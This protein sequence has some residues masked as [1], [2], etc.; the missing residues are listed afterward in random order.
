M[1]MPNQPWVPQSIQITSFLGVGP[2]GIH[3]NLDHQI[4]VLSGNNGSGKTTITSAIEWSL[5]G[6]L[7]LVPDY[8]VDGVGKNVATY[9]SIMHSDDAET[10]VTL[11]FTKR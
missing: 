10:N 8:Q 6:E 5:F 11:T 7:E 9:R 1:S 2:A 3:V 4:T